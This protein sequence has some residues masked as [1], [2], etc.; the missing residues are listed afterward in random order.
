MSHP[1]PKRRQ[2]DED[3]FPVF[4][5]SPGCECYACTLE[6]AQEDSWCRLGIQVL[7]ARH[8]HAR[9]SGNA[10]R[11]EYLRRNLGLALQKYEPLD[12]EVTLQ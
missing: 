2:R 5:Y 11:T 8:A 10:K 3:G 7:G 12:D 9:D 6:R 1:L 4:Y